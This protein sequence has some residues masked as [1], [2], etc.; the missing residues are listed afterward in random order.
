MPKLQL[1]P[2]E[3]ATITHALDVTN[4][5]LTTDARTILSADVDKAHMWRLTVTRFWPTH[6]TS[7]HCARGCCQT[8]C[9]NGTR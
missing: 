1:T 7:C 2:E 5:T 8:S 6:S 9:R 4:S 3:Y